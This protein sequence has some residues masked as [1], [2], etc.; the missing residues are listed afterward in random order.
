LKTNEFKVASVSKAVCEEPLMARVTGLVVFYNW[1]IVHFRH[2][3]KITKAF[4]TV[5]L[6]FP[7]L[8]LCI[9]LG[10]KKWF[11]YILGD[12][13]IWLL[14]FWPGYWWWVCSQKIG[15][16]CKKIL[17]HFFSLF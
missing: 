10:A 14:C 7:R 12:T 3:L 13:L 11:G 8:R 16:F 5:G 1:V 17:L 15:F 9:N 4:R 6:L 2:A